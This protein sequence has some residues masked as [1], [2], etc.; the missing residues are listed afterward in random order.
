MLP[1]MFLPHALFLKGQQKCRQSH[2]H[3]MTLRLDLAL[4]FLPRKVVT[5][6]RMEPSCQYNR[7]Y[8]VLSKSRHQIEIGLFLI[9]IQLYVP[10]QR[11]CCICLFVQQ[12]QGKGRQSQV[13]LPWNS[14]VHHLQCL[15]IQRSRLFR[16]FH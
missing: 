10:L 5:P 6:L 12:T 16:N 7:H 14:F 9:S 8:W 3:N 2:G 1:V 4:P 11:S 15:V 13:L